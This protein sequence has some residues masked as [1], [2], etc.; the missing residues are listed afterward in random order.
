[1]LFPRRAGGGGGEATHKRPGSDESR[2]VVPPHSAGR[3][4]AYAAKVGWGRAMESEGAP[5]SQ[6]TTRANHQ[7]HVLGGPW[8]ARSIASFQTIRRGGLPDKDMQIEQVFGDGCAGARPFRVR[9]TSK[10]GPDRDHWT[11][12]QGAK[13]EARLM[14]ALRYAQSRPTA[15]LNMP[16]PS[17]FPS[18]ASGAFGGCFGGNPSNAPIPP[19]WARPGPARTREAG[20]QRVWWIDLDS[21]DFLLF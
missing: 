5:A 1:M 7:W 14:A 13:S 4:V 2:R 21:I 8:P 11:Q 19:R 17:A 10:P 15:S 12:Q 18:T 3:H 9:R 16:Y 20:V 6:P